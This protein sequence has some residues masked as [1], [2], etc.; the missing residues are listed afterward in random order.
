MIL[1]S[2]SD[3]SFAPGGAH[4]HGCVITTLGGTPVAWK[5]YKQPFPALSTAEAELI[6]VIET[7]VV[8]NSIACLVEE[9]IKEVHKY[10]KCDNT[11]AVSI[12]SSA[13]GA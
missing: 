6:E 2:V 13:T 1:E 7:V 10:L 9:M 4:S 8:G 11:A 5:S 3:A 12:A